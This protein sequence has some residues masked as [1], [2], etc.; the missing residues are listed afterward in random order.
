MY[1]VTIYLH[2]RENGI[3]TFEG[4][5]NNLSFRYRINHPTLQIDY[6][7]GELT[8]SEQDYVIDSILKGTYNTIH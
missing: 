3:E 8:D 6:L 2:H 1:P 4:Q 7:G 5:Y